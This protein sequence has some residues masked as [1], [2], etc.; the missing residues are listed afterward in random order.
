[1]VAMSE[2]YKWWDKQC[3]DCGVA[4]RILA[5]TSSRNSQ[6]PVV[7]CAVCLDQRVQA[8]K[9]ARPSRKQ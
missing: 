5:S 4:M 2:R 8:V 6:D 9:V 7:L 1:M 3:V